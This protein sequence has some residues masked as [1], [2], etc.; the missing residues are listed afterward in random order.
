MLTLNIIE[1]AFISFKVSTSIMSGS[2]II[3]VKLILLTCSSCS[4]VSLTLAGT[5]Q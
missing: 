5:E 4:F 1:L 2:S 3:N